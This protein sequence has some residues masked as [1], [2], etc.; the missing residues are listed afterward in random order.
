[1]PDIYDVVVCGAGV[2]GASI[3]HHLAARG[4]KVAVVDSSGPAAAASGASD[5]AV[6]VCSKRPGLMT[7]LAVE[8]LEYCESLAKPGN[9]LAGVFANRP[10]YYFSASDIENEALDSLRARLDGMQ[11]PVTVKSD[12][13][14]PD[15][16][17]ETGATVRRVMEITGEGHM[18][19]FSATDAFLHAGKVD[20]FWPSAVREI[21]H[22]ATKVRIITDDGPLEAGY[23]VLAMGVATN[24]FMPELPIS[25]RSGQLIVTDRRQTRRTLPGALTAASYLLS[26]GGAKGDLAGPPVVIDPLETGQYL[27][28]STREDGGNHRQTDFITVKRLLE[29][30]VQ[31]YPPLLALRVIRVFA[32]VRAAVTDGLPIVGA[33]PGSERIVVAAGFEGDG[34][35]LS[36]LVGR[37]V[38]SLIQG[39][40]VSADI[41]QL[42]PARFYERRVAV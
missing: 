8:A 9:V 17:L 25:P 10:S 12:R 24:G 28:G 29:F 41:A 30:A 35:C 11:G 4:M 37:E 1:M 16:G 23:V 34:I 3:C 18:L 21:D 20:H 36:A 32:G 13:T 2:V 33:I 26:K 14:G 6:S 5:G 31:C 40:D 39:K 42:S 38:A 22:G 19:G 7:Q 15:S 27:V